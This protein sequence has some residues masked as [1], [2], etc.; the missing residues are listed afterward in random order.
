MLLYRRDHKKFQVNFSAFNST[1]EVDTP[2]CSAKNLE[3]Y[4][5]RVVRHPEARVILEVR[6]CLVFYV[7]I[8]KNTVANVE[9]SDLSRLSYIDT[10]SLLN[11][12]LTQAVQ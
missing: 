5:K 1:Y 7:Y 11:R 4:L 8:L 6:D 9:R 10:N 3:E 12:N 2:L